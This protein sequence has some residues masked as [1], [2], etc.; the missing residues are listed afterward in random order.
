MS[1]TPLDNPLERLGVN[2]N[3]MNWRGLW[4][5][6]EQYFL[7]DV[8]VSPMNNASYILNGKTAL[9][10]GGDPSLNPDWIELSATTTG[11]ASV[12]AGVG[13]AMTGTGTNPIVNNTGVIT[14]TAGTGLNN[15]GTATNPILN[16]TG[17]IAPIA[18]AGI[19]ITGTATNPIITNSGIRTI[20]GGAGLSVS[21]GNNPSIVNTGILSLTA[22]SGLASSGGQNPTLTNSGVLSFTAG[23]GLANT[24]TATNPVVDNT[25]ILS[26][27]AGT[28]IASTGGQN[29]TLSATI[30]PRLSRIVVFN[31]GFFGA[32]P[33]D[34]ITS[35]PPNNITISQCGLGTKIGQDFANGVPDPDGT[36]LVDFSPLKFINIAGAFTPPAS[37]TITLVDSSTGGGPYSYLMSNAEGG[38]VLALAQTPANGSGIAGNAQPFGFGLVAFNINAI[39]ASGLRQLNEI[40]ITNNT[41]GIWWVCTNPNALFAQ[42]YPL[43]VE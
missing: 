27:T 34:T 42:Y 25:G 5:A 20:V 21:T 3:G 2:P 43:G 8:A 23:T 6:T 32:N 33:M 31:V 29:P 35:G 39:R 1:L 15:T 16:S 36:W 7:N 19:Q 28:G 38:S 10:D 41:G 30:F 40:H 18:G 14:I 9:L 13:I 37:L 4:T 12:N 11:V 22:G 26:I 17:V 24:G